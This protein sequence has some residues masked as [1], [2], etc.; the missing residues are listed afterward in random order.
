MRGSNY[1]ILREGRLD[2]W[3]HRGVKGQRAH[4]G[5]DLFPVVGL[6]MPL[7]YPPFPATISAVC[8]RSG[9]SPDAEI[10]YRESESHRPPWDYSMAVDRRVN[11]SLY[12]NFIWLRGSDPASQGCFVLFCHLQNEPVLQAL[13]VDQPVTAYTPVG[14]VGNSGNAV[15]SRAQLHLELH[16]PIEDAYVCT[17]CWPIR[18][19]MT[20]FDPT[21]SL[22]GAIRRR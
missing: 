7:I 14:V 15:R 13:K 10:D 12:G 16:C 21:P 5:V 2:A 22:R 4:D 11:L 20:S 19:G 17:R 18:D 3:S 8:L 6:E 9:N 1:H